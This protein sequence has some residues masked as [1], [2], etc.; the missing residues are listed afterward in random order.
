[1][2]NLHVVSWN[3]QKG[4]GTD[5][6]RNLDRTAGV[7]ADV[8]ADAIGLQEVLRTESC[9]QAGLLA[10]ALEMSLAWGLRGRFVAGRLVTRCSYAAR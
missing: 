3:I 4:I 10:R 7:L 2:T 1:V 6:R 9:D 8:G 5:F